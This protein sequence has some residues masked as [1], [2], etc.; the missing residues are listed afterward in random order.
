[1]YSGTP[2]SKLLIAIVV[3]IVVERISICHQDERLNLLLHGNQLSAHSGAE[4][5]VRP[6]PVTEQDQ[7][8]KAGS[9]E[10]DKSSRHSS[11]H[12]TGKAV[13]LEHF[14]RSGAG[15]ATASSGS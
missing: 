14:R 9:I 15:E 6:R 13:V 11:S 2:L 4:N 8:G 1:M 3:N 7:E 10:R 12:R 5:C